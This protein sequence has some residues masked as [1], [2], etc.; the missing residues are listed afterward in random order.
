MGV[1]RF[2]DKP[3]KLDGKLDDPFWQTGSQNHDAWQMPLSTADSKSNGS[4]DLAM[5]AYDENY[6]YAGFQCQK[7]AG[8]PYQSPNRSRPRDADLTHRD[9][10]EFSIDVDRDYLSQNCF[11]IDHR[12]W[13]K[14]SCSGSLGWNPNW[15]V[16]QSEDE[17][18][19]TIE[20]AIPLNCLVPEKIAANETVWAI[21]L[22]RRGYEPTNLWHDSTTQPLPASLPAPM[23][24]R[25]TLQA[26][27]VD[28]DLLKFI[29]PV[30]ETVTK[31]TLGN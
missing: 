6:F 19:W 26:R 13:V 2:T 4:S 7:I 27:P 1:C 22:A 17:T 30:P 21:K 5:F 18:T 9:R 11:V 15:F 31:L 16:S 23:G 8:Q 29:N 3:P 12:G 10:I 20:L 14:E 25:N 28:F 24:I